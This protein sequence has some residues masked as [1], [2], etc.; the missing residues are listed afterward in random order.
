MVADGMTVTVRQRITI[1]RSATMPPRIEP[2]RP[3]AN[4]RMGRAAASMRRR[5]M[6]PVISAR[7]TQPRTK[8][9]AIAVVAGDVDLAGVI[10]V[11]DVT[12]DDR[13]VFALH[14]SAGRGDMP[15][16]SRTLL[17]AH[18]AAHH[19]D[20]AHDQRAPVDPRGAP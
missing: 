1:A 4:E 19:R 15:V 17:D 6:R 3:S 12:A 16:D 5:S 14:R 11:D 7:S 8:S 2:T 13:A 9:I 18:R 10:V 20:G